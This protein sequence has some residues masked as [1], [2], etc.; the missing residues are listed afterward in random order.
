MPFKTEGAA[1]SLI[2]TPSQ[3]FSDLQRS[4][5]EYQAYLSSRGTTVLFIGERLSAK[6]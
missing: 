4:P 6:Y 2:Y 1:V 5:V 3:K